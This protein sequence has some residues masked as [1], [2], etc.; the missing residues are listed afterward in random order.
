MLTTQNT[1]TPAV[2]QAKAWAAIDALADSRL[3]VALYERLRVKH[4][5][6]SADLL[7]KE[8]QTFVANKRK[9]KK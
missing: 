3:A 8:I 9:G 7:I 2:Q 6:A 4:P 1:E 5:T